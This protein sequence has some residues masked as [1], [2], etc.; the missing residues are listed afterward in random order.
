M[1]TLV[2]G[3]V[4]GNMWYVGDGVTGSSTTAA[5][6]PE[7]GVTEAYVGDLYLHLE[8]NDDDNGHVYQCT[9]KGNASTAKWVYVG[10]IIGPMPD[11]CDELTSTSTTKAATA[12]AVRKLK[13]LIDTA[14]IYP[15][16]ISFN[17]TETDYSMSLT[18]ENI[19]TT[20]TI[21]DSDGNEGTHSYT[22]A[23]NTD[24]VTVNINIGQD[25]GY[26]SEG[27]VVVKVASSAA[28]IKNAKLYGNDGLVCDITPNMWGAVNELAAEIK[29]GAT[30]T[31]GSGD[32]AYSYRA[33]NIS[34]KIAGVLTALFP[35]THA[36]AVWMDKI[37]GNTVHDEINLKQPKTLATP[38]TI[39]GVSQ[40]TAEGA[41]GALNTAKAER[42]DISSISCTGSTNDTGSTI[43]AGTYFYLNN[44]LCK[45]LADIADDAA[46]TLNTNYKVVTTGEELTA[47]NSKTG[48]YYQ[49]T[50][51][52]VTYRQALSALYS[53]V[54]WSKVNVATSTVALKSNIFA[55]TGYHYFNTDTGMYK[56][57]T[58]G[59]GGGKPSVT[60]L[61]LSSNP[62]LQQY[63]FSDGSTTNWTDD[64]ATNID[65]R[66]YYTE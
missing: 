43:T 6:F 32:D 39:G 15:K 59:W 24:D 10:N 11:L 1:N 9:L 54:D 46:F 57:T 28:A 66:L 65:V 7:S 49:Y 40:T 5:V 35:V 14:G 53:L 34:K 58:T 31:G 38:I 16:E 60:L 18:I 48:K 30:I 2:I 61:I 29:P 27:A 26:V 37:G 23:G 50:E 22:K 44:V 4:R 41:L 20:I 47:L 3:K 36:K 19:S 52:N 8:P 25:I 42:G 64:T 12:N 21:T 62:T 51:T 17:Y 45:A 56:Y 55:E 13:N 63:S 33:G